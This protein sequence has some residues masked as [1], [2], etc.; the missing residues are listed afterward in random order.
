MIGVMALNVPDTA[1]EARLR[2]ALQSQ[3]EFI[4]LIT[5]DLVSAGGKRIR[6]LI[7]Y[8]AAQVLGATPNL[9]SWTH[10]LDLA[11]CVELL[12]SASL[13]HD[14]LID[15]A[16]TRRGHQAAFKRFGNVVSVMSGDFMLARL[17]ILLSGMPQGSLLTREFGQT[18]S[19]ICEGEVLQFQTAAYQDYALAHYLK[20]IYGKTAVLTELAAS[21][22][23]LMLGGNT[24]QHAALQTFGREF[25]MAFQ[26][27]D[28]LLDLTSDSATLGK[29][30]G[31]DLRE[32][33]ATMPVLLLLEGPNAS[34][35]RA[36]V[37]RSAEQEGDLARILEL[38]QQEGV[39]ERTREDIRSRA[40]KAVAALQIFS[41][42]AARE[43]LEQLAQREIAR[44]Q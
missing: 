41:P 32:G 5:D 19:I 25:G 13:L 18:A 11:V 15:D 44:A 8:L 34:E 27:Q 22:P 7:S 26:M 1:F 17:L 20:I 12:H 10:V 9:P 28:D 43:A 3:V 33:K 31:S 40:A 14:D 30:S 23:A 42:S 21:T 24:E 37:Q 38:A 29:P 6:P 39:I 36:I 35:V 16:E 2:G 4:E